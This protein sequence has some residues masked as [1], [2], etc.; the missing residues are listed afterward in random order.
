[1]NN[2]YID[3]NTFEIL[4]NIFEVDDEIAESISLLNKKGYH[5]LFSCSGHLKEPVYYKSV[6][7]ISEFNDDRPKDS[8][9]VEIDD[10]NF[11][12]LSKLKTISIYVNFDKEYNFINLPEG[13]IYDNEINIL[14]HRINKYK[15]NER[16]DVNI[17][18]EEMIKY[19]KILLDWVNNL[20]SKR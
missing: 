20:P 7:N 3:K 4:E 12:L 13:F 9:I 16:I 19:N 5:T 8:Y 2:K 1:M 14:E 10:K 6:C 17:L 18:E 15:N 11:T